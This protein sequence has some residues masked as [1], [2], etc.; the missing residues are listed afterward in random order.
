MLFSPFDSR[1]VRN[2]LILTLFTATSVWLSA[3][4]PQVRQIQKNSTAM[5]Y[6]GSAE[7]PKSFEVGVASVSGDLQ[8]D[9]VNVSASLFNFTIRETDEVHP[10]RLRNAYSSESIVSFHS[11]RI[12]RRRDGLLEVQG[13]MVVSQVF[14]QPAS[15]HGENAALAYVSRNFQSSRHV[16][17]VFTTLG[18][19]Q[20]WDGDQKIAT[21]LGATSVDGEAFPQ[22]SLAI[23]DIAWPV[24]SEEPGCGTSSFE[25]DNSPTRSCPNAQAEDAPQSP[26]GDVVTIELRLVLR[27]VE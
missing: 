18:Q 1:T 24:A 4:Q 10:L 23:Q 15:A 27:A 20:V 16:T 14:S 3:Q 9:F 6:L 5:V 13:E 7:D 21:I 22:L 17:F 2:A 25:R 11:T 19:Q 8:L 12:Q 26:A